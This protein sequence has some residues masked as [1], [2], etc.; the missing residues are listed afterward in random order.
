MG[1]KIEITGSITE[2]EMRFTPQNQRVLEFRLNAAESVK[3]KHSGQW[4]EVGSPLWVS[5]SLW[6]QD[7]E[8]YEGLQKGDRVTV[9]GA[10][11]VETY[12]KKDQTEGL[13]YKLRFPR[14]KG[15]IPKRGTGTVPAPVQASFQQPDS[16][17][18]ATQEQP[19]FPISQGAPA[20][21]QPPF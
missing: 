2:P 9:E 15:I 19:H 14:M 3:D 12:S 10:L 5:V 7:A 11:V 4:S 1:N 20:V 6:E 21:D 13:R 18:W 16:D 8:R 17:P